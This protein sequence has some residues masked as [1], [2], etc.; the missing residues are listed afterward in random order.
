MQL[1]YAGSHL[2]SGNIELLKDRGEVHISNCAI[3]IRKV[4]LEVIII[5]PNPVFTGGSEVGQCKQGAGMIVCIPLHEL[6]LIPAQQIGVEE[7]RVMGIED[8]LCVFDI[9]LVVV[10]QVQDVHEGNGVN[11]SVKLIH[12][13]GSSGLQR[14]NDKGEKIDEPDRA[15]G[16]IDIC[17][18]RIGLIITG[19]DQRKEF[20]LG[21]LVHGISN[22]VGVHA[23]QADCI[24]QCLRYI[25]GIL[26]GVGE[27]AGQ[28]S[29]I[30]T[31]YHDELVGKPVGDHL[32]EGLRENEFEAASQEQL[33]GIQAIHGNHDGT[34]IVS[35]CSLGEQGSYFLAGFYLE[36][37]R[38][39]F[40]MI[41]F[42]NHIAVDSQSL[43]E[44][45]AL[46]L[47][48]QE[49]PEIHD[50]A[51]LNP[52]LIHDKVNKELNGLSLGQAAVGDQRKVGSGMVRG[53]KILDRKSVV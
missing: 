30:R 13:Q 15:E 38:S 10:E 32:N 31:V 16:F 51:I 11:G 33:F 1:C 34:C 48:I 43:G 40:N 27:A 35:L 26:F 14:T 29:C 19:V 3:L 42:E 28:M 41:S 17:R 8:Q 22:R 47:G 39:V 36:R 2:V 53:G 50:N 37:R 4:A 20:G 18:Q 6:N 9:D 44:D 46:M 23:E 52:E 25:D 45:L 21:I 12:D 49:Q 24:V 7:N 5:L